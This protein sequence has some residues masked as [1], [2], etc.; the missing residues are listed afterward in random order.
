[1]KTR[2]LV[3][4]CLLPPLLLL[5]LACPAW[6]TA[7]LIGAMSVVAVHEF[8]HTTGLVSHKR[9]ISYSMLMALAVVAQ[10][11]FGAGKTLVIAVLF[12]YFMLLF[13]EL[14]ASHAQLSFASLTLA[15]FSAI[16]IPWSLA[17]LLRLRMLEQGKFLIIIS[18]VLAFTSDT[19]AYFAGRFF[20]K[21][22]LA[23]VIS[24]KKTVEGMIGGVF[25]CVLFMFLYGAVLQFAFRFRVNYLYAA[26]YGVLGSLASVVGDLVFSVAKRQTGIKDYGKLLPGHGGI[27]DRF[28]STVIVAPLTEL[29]VLFIP[30]LE[31]A[32]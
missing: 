23:P 5:V 20:G 30:I 2:I 7:L 28:D 4:V 19:G 8:L 29:L 12:V 9:V 6:A 31:V 1:M 16:V 25:S 14:L 13:L 27:L 26:I 17:A 18:F 10:S 3:A 22:K 21:H 32:A 11:Y 24:P 15:A